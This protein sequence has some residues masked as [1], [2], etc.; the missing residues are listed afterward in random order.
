MID[1]A[2]HY[3]RMA[4]GVY[5]YLRSKPLGNPDAV[6]R[7][8]LEN[9]E[10]NFLYL[11]RNVIFASP[12]NPF[13]AMLVAAGCRP[14]DLEDSLRRDGLEK[15]LADLSAT[16]VYLTHDEFKGKQPIVR[17][18]RHIPAVTSDFRN[19]LVKTRGENRSSGS[20]SKG[21][22]TPRN[23]QGQLYREVRLSVRDREFWIH[24]RPHAALYPILPS[25]TGLSAGLRARRLGYR[26]DRWFAV[27]GGLRDS[28]HYR[29]VTRA[30]VAWANLLGAGAPPPFYLPANDFS[31]AAEWIARSV[32]AGA[33]GVVEGMTSPAVRVAAAARERNLDLTGVTFLVGG[34]ALTDGKRAVIER[35]GAEVYTGYPTSEI[36]GV[37][38]ACRQMRTGNSVHFYEDGLAV[39]TCRRVAPLSETEVDALRFTTLLPFTA[40]VLIN[41]EMD[42]SGI[43]EP[44]RCD[45]AYSR[46]GFK[47]QV[48]AISSFGKLTGQGMT[49]VG[50]DMVR[51]LEEILPA[52]LGGAA[53]DYQLI[54][55]DGAVQTELTLRVSPRAARD[56][57]QI[58]RCFLDEVRQFFGG[59][60]AA[61]M[62]RHAEGVEVEIAEPETTFTGKV[63]TLHLL[64]SPAERRRA[65]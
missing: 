20:R 11:V 63:L 37:G 15:T 2:I 13:H 46:M 41:T 38:H 17:A 5:E 54:E 18:G 36:G 12:A 47:R 24:H 59:A 56:A 1:E 30:L 60:L 48:R 9:R 23:L 64:G 53:G 42:D 43:V 25:F 31:P 35:T 4:L 21:T 32:A 57:D 19:P 29:A 44:V 26:L 33:P 14:G 16:G 10:R 39:I 61:R 49:L 52:R 22:R 28:G 65:T 8:N 51:L 27:G 34:E 58:R 6:I 7:R 62:W 3:S 40:H 50:T 45:C 55:R